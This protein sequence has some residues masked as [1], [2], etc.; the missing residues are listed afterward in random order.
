MYQNVTGWSRHW[1]KPQHWELFHVEEWDFSN[2]RC[3]HG[4]NFQ[5]KWSHWPACCPG[6]LTHSCCSQWEPFHPFRHTL[7]GVWGTETV[8]VVRRKLIRKVPLA[9]VVTILHVCGFVWLDT[10]LEE[11][12][13]TTNILPWRIYFSYS[14]LTKPPAPTNIL[15]PDSFLTCLLICDGNENRRAGFHCCWWEKTV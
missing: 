13:G 1:N 6:A 2:R 7:D 9:T 10:W 12:I 5:N 14:P 8:D 11:R 3:A 15:T 4:W